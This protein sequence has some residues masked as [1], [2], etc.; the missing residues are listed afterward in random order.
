MDHRTRNAHAHTQSELCMSCKCVRAR[1]VPARHSSACTRMRTSMLV[2]QRRHPCHRRGTR[3]CR[4]TLYRTSYLSW[5][6]G[7]ARMTS[8]IV[9]LF[10]TLR[11]RNYLS[12]LEFKSWN[13][14]VHSTDELT[15]GGKDARGTSCRSRS[16]K[17]RRACERPRVRRSNFPSAICV[18]ENLARLPSRFI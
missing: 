6:S 14:V 17:R 8:Y 16:G 2:R 3:S 15:D 1:R 5:R 9:V 18:D 11:G 13:E 4:Y 7:K 12:N 10:A